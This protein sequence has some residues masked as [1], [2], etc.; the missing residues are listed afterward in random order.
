MLLAWAQHELRDLPW[1]HT[2]DPWAILVAE[3][4]LQQTQVERVVPRWQSFL[5]DLPTPSDC[6]AVP[7]AEIIRRWEGLGYNQRAVRLHQAARHVVD[8]HAGRLP[9]TLEDL[10]AIPGVGPYTARAV[11]AFAFEQDHGVV[12]TNAARVLARAV[13]GRRLTAS[14]AQRAADASVPPGHGWAWNQAVLDIGARW[15][16]GTSP[17]C[18]DCPILDGCAWA[19][20]GFA[21]PDPAHRTS[22]VSGPQSRFQG[23]DRQGRGRLVDALRRGPVDVDRIA[24][25]AGWP[26][27]A[28]RARRIADSLVADG[29]ARY[30]GGKLTLP[31]GDEA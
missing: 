30:D 15:C 10:L 18:D 19:G 7:V 11:L 28:V 17:R 4:M 23:S 6:A 16:V 22:G 26:D 5:A 24:H 29:L 31:G 3:V 25:T 9:D 27:D 8:R 13:S 20:E 1:R 21:A 12:D 2:R 14:E